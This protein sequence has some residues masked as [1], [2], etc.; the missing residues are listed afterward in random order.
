MRAR[1]RLPRISTAV[2]ARPTMPAN[3]GVKPEQ[4]ITRPASGS[5]RYQRAHR[6]Q[7]LGHSVLGQAL[8]P[9][10]AG[11][12]MHHPEGTVK[13]TAWPGSPPP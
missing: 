10:A 2:S 7:G 13:N 3:I 8:Q 12:E 11:L 4:Q 1:W 9:G 5:S 6:R